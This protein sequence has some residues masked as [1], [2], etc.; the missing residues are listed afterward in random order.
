MSFHGNKHCA[1]KINQQSEFAVNW[2]NLGLYKS[3]AREPFKQ[4]FLPQFKFHNFH[5]TPDV[6]YQNNPASLSLIVNG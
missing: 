6:N 1:S 5:I 3:Q 2:G 4:L